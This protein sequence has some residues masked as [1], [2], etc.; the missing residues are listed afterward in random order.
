MKYSKSKHNSKTCNR[1]NNTNYCF[2]L[3][4]ANSHRKLKFKANLSKRIVCKLIEIR[5]QKSPFDIRKQ[6]K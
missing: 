4:V 6:S 3:Q 1:L 2:Y 5:I